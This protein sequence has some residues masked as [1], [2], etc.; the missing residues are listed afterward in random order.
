M[1]RTLD[2][3]DIPRRLTQA[4]FTLFKQQGYNATGIQQITDEAGVPKGSFY[5][6]FESKDAFA[7][8]I[9]RHYAAGV[10]DA[11]ATGLKEAPTAP[12]AALRHLFN[13]FIAH[14]EQSSCPGCLIGNFA[15]E[16]AE[17]SP[18]CRAELAAVMHSWR[19][20]LGTLIEQAQADGSVRTDLDAPTLAAFFWDAWEGALLRMRIEHSSRPLHAALALM[21]DKFFQ[22]PAEISQA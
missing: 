17:S 19:E 18:A 1:S 6:H 2:K 15:A 12:L 14:H 3:T 11:W 9:I 10:D 13:D 4:G 8:H 22:P 7:G 20:R 21:L 5:N 16:M